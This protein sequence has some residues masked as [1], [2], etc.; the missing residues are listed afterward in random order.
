MDVPFS[1]YMNFIKTNMRVFF[2]LP[3]DHKFALKFLNSQCWKPQLFVW[4]KQKYITCNSFIFIGNCLDNF[5][6]KS[7]IKFGFHFSFCP[8]HVISTGR[9]MTNLVSNFKCLFWFWCQPTLKSDLK[10]VQFTQNYLC[11]VKAPL[12][13][14]ESALNFKTQPHSKK[15]N[16]TKYSRFHT[17]FVIWRP[18][19]MTWCRHKYIGR[20]CVLAS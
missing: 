5:I 4:Q 6:D 12:K 15:N 2:S 17:K 9:R 8:D 13:Y 7:G 14:L 1:E 19:E 10:G 11:W 20:L 16:S 18:V 3:L